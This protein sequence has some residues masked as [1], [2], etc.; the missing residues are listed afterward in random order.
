MPNRIDSNTIGRLPIM[1]K[2]SLLLLILSLGVSL[3]AFAAPID[4]THVAAF[5]V[6]SATQHYMN[7]LSDS[8]RAKSDAYFEGG[9]VLQVVNLLYGGLV[10]FVF[11]R[12]GCF[13][14]DRLYNVCV[15][16]LARV[17]CSHLQQI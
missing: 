10:A 5:S 7:M 1:K 6:D 17:P 4:S 3:H 13:R 14:N 16:Y 2:L 12:L 8:A 11:L 9:Y 15:V